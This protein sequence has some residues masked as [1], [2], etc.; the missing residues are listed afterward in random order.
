MIWFFLLLG[1]LGL[2]SY[3]FIVKRV[4]S[5]TRT[6]AWLLWLVVMTPA[7]SL[8]VWTVLFGRTPMPIGL[9]ILLFLGCFLLYLYLIQRGR[10]VPDPRSAPQEVE[11]VQSSEP[12]IELPTE[13]VMTRPINKE[14]E[15]HLKSCFP[16]SVYYLQHL[17]YRPQAVICRG[18]LRSKPEVAYQTIRENIEAHFGK[19]FYV[20]FQEGGDRK[21]FFVLVPNP[22]AQLDFSPRALRRPKVAVI[23]AIVTA[24]TTTWAGQQLLQQ[25]GMRG[26]PSF[27]EGVP[28]AIALMGFFA[29]REGGHYWTTLRYGIPATLPYF[30]PVLPLPQLP[31]GTVGAFLQ[32]RSPIPNRKALFDVGM[33][34]AMVGLGVAVIL[35]VVGLTQSQ[36]VNATEHPSVFKF[37][38]LL[39]QYSLLLTLACKV[40]FGNALTAKSA[41]ALNPIAVAGWLGILFTAFNLMPVGQLDG[42]RMVHAVYGQRAGAMIGQVARL[43]LLVLALMQP[44]LLLWAVLL[45]LLPTIDEPAL[46]DV[47]ELD[48]TRDMIGLI[49]LFLL[50]VIILPTPGVLLNALG[51]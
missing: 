38:A 8:M 2:V 3:A 16:W 32:I 31:I 45:F 48:S 50:I 17:E 11:P 23:L 10:I 1:F 44:H 35:L 27:W 46:N 12:P 37:E 29:I 42:G 41:I 33:F 20:V 9:A 26:N 39:P 18:Q 15:D 22:F 30:I 5:V 14:E 21:P 4:T 24:F 40:V 7:F 51:M 28:Y 6:P 34:G 43:L 13:P 49:A 19:R 25:V 47:T 36:I